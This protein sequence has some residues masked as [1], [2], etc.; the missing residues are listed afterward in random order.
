MQPLDAPKQL[1]GLIAV[2]ASGLAC[3]EPHPVGDPAPVGTDPSSDATGEVQ[4]ELTTVPA[5]AQCLRVTATP[6][7]GSTMTQ[8]QSLTAGA[9]S[10]SLSLTA[11]PQGML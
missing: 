11:L 6:A 3:A 8:T 9:S 4:F 7:S 1:F 10:S 2:I 5:G